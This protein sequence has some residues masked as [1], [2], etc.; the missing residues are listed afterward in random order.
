MNLPQHTQPPNQDTKHRE[1]A[2]YMIALDITIA[3]E[4]QVYFSLYVRG[5]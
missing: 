5:E 2:L 3:R 4:V 1:G